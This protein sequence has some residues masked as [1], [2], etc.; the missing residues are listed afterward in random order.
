MPR[1][2]RSQPMPSERTVATKMQGLEVR[3]FPVAGLKPHPRNYRKHPQ[4]QLDHLRASIRQY[5]V[6]RNCVVS[7]DGYIL[8]GHGVREAAELEGLAEIPGYALSV[9]HDDPKAEKFLVLDNEVSRL[10]EDDDRALAALLA[11]IQRTDGLDGTGWDEADLAAM[12]GDIAEAEFGGAEQTQTLKDMAAKWLVTLVIDE[13]TKR[14]VDDLID[15]Q[16][17]PGEHPSATVGRIFAAQV[18]NKS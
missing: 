15:A 2:R 5:G 17:L 9:N 14:S 18:V 4:A 3:L 13:T 7:A 12:L 16:A 6:V 11:D 1:G 10:A 8:A